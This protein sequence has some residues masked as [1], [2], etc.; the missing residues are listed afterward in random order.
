MIMRVIAERKEKR[1]RV[2]R[3]T[4][5]CFLHPII[6]FS[7]VTQQFCRTNSEIL[8]QSISRNDNTEKAYMHDGTS[9]LKAVL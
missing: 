8:S 3:P 4:K 6:N 1:K 7:N 5:N 2:S 9:K